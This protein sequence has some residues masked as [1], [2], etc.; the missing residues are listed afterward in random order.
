MWEQDWTLPEPPVSTYSDDLMSNAKN[1]SDKALVVITRV[2]GEGTD[3]PTDMLAENITY[4]NNSS[5]YDDFQEGDHF[6]R[7]SKSEQDM[8]EMVCA[9]FDNV[10]LV[11]NGANAFELGFTEEYPQIKSVI[12]AAGAGQSGFNSLGNIL[13][14]DVNPS[15]RTIDTF[16]YDLKES[17]TWNNFGYFMYDNME[18]FEASNSFSQSTSSPTF[19]N[20]VEGIYVG[21]RYYETAAA[22]GLIDYDNTVLYPFGHGLSYTS[23][24]QEMGTI[25]ESDGEIS[26]D[27]TV[28]N[29]GSVAGKDVVEVFYNPPYTNGGIEKAT[30]NLVAFDKTDVLEPGESQ[31][32]TLTFALEDMASFDD[33]GAG[34]YILEQGDYIISINSDSHNIID[35]QTYTQDEAITYGNDNKRESDMVAAVTQFD[36]AKGDVT[37]L[38]REDGFANYEEAIA[39][40][41]SLS[42]P[43]H[44]KETFVNNSNYVA[45]DY[46]NPEDVAPVTG[47]NNNLELVDLRGKDYDDPEWD[48]LLDQLTVS[49][50][51]DLIA[52]GGYQTTMISS[53][54][55][56]ATVD[57]DGPAS[58]NNNFTGVGSIGFPSSVMIAA[59]WSEDLA[60]AFGQSIGKMADEMNVSG[61]YAPAMN[62]HRSAF[63]G[64]NFEY[65]SEDG[66]ISG[67][68]AAN[69][70]AGAREYGVYAYMKH[71]A[72]ND[73]ETNRNE[74]L[75]TWVNEQSIREIYLK[76][77]ELAVKE[78]EISA[79]MSAFNYIGTTFAGANNELLN[80][81]LRDEWG[82]RGMVLTDFFGVAGYGYMNA[83]QQIRN[84]GDICLAPFDA[85]DNIVKDTSSATSQLAMRQASKNVLY[86]VANSRAYESENMETG[87]L[88]WQIAAVAIDVVIVGALIALELTVIRKGYNK[89]K[90]S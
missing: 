18:E 70:V 12:W 35:S 23:F 47:A 6:L 64:R 22:E 56:L 39:A 36:Y 62:I 53:V 5:E 84:G 15:G 83:D 42:M 28:T 43:D 30:A 81:V 66:F 44:Q 14:G 26:F 76:P 7:L 87:P 90:E 38:S 74:M 8:V 9:N 68:M 2:G 41:A 48:A 57:C 33:E 49:D 78:G 19:V 24:Q 50:M 82:F 20:Y 32:L 52:L 46:N 67:K 89:R 85:G 61:W 29:T 79:A 59:T 69:A 80:V 37:Y 34:A 31:T 55:K 16:V 1:Y 75:C 54:G 21:Y 71:Y 73:Q 13:K 45:A 40:P 10:T 63:A 88:G 25:S 77:F 4:N 65:Y 51:V 58:I 17:P 60:H 72:L 11:Y 27:V 3:L 86:T